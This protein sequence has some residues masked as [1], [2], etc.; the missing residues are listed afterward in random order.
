E[1]PVSETGTHLLARILAERRTRWEEEQLAKMRERGITPKDDKWKLAYK[2]LRGPDVEHL[3]MLPE[4]W[5]YTFL[6]PLLSSSRKGMVTGPFGSLLKKHEH[7]DEGVPVFG[8]E[9]IA[10]MRFVAGNKIYITPDKA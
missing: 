10:A 7:C 6:Q 5:C 1:H 9:N 2:E 4:G 8:I 3:P